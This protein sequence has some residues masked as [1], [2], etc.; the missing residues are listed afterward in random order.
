MDKYIYTH[1]FQTYGH[2]SVVH[3]AFPASRNFWSTWVQLILD[4]EL[5]RNQLNSRYILPVCKESQ[6]YEAHQAEFQLKIQV[7]QGSST[8]QRHPTRSKKRTMEN[9]IQWYFQINNMWSK[10]RFKSEDTKITFGPMRWTN[11]PLMKN[12]KS[13]PIEELKAHKLCMSAAREWCLI[14]F[15]ATQASMVTSAI[16]TPAL[17]AVNDKMAHPRCSFSCN[18]IKS[19]EITPR[20][21]A[22]TRKELFNEKTAWIPS[23]KLTS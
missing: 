3:I 5:K 18:D 12:P 8:S 22:L 1:G 16:A 15:C 21:P 23:P 17:P 2:F 13:A 10:S 9:K 14:L 4:R 20:K 6:A 7:Q 19:M 11:I